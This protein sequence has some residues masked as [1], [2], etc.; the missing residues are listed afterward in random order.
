MIAPAASRRCARSRTAWRRSWLLLPLALALATSGLAAP[1]IRPIARIFD[2]PFLGDPSAAIPVSQDVTDGPVAVRQRDGYAAPGIRAGGFFILP[3]LEIDE[4][5]DDNIFATKNDRASDFATIITPSVSIESLWSRHGLG[6]QAFGQFTEFAEHGTEDTQQGGFNLTGRL[7]ITSR[8]RLSGFASYSREAED[9][10]EPDDEGRRHPSLFDR[11]IGWTRFTHQFNR[12]EL[13]ID[14]EVQRFDYAAGFDADRDRVELSVEPRLSYE[15]SPNLKPF[16]QLG[17]LDRNFDA[18]VNDAGDD[19][20]SQTY[21]AMAGM[22]FALG[23]ALAGEIAGGVFHTEFDDS[24]FD[25]VTSPAVE[26]QLTWEVT[27]LTTVTGTISRR[28]AVTTKSDTSS[29]IVTAASIRVDH[30]LLRNVMLGG[31]IDYRNEDFQGS[32][33]VDDRID[34]RI[35]VNYLLNRN[36]G[37]SLGYRHTTRDST[38]ADGDFDDN[39]IQVGVDLKM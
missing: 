35:G 7:D 18:A 14:N 34:V 5:Y 33:R 2:P 1:I 17:Y 22:D 3:K 38:V 13:R 10:S 19:P 9:R 28:E 29:K 8:D 30:E 36:A 15:V 24:T 37:L 12:L 25:P 4:S 32:N 23:P 16:L 20:D 26:G 31:E 39:V 6:L 21:V 11:F 27:R